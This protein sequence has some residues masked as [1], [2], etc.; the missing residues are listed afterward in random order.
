MKAILRIHVATLMA[1]AAILAAQNL[2]SGQGAGVS[3]QI[4]AADTPPATKPVAVDDGSGAEPEQSGFHHR[5]IIR[6]PRVGV[7]DPIQMQ[8]QGIEQQKIQLQQMAEGEAAKPGE[9]LK[10]RLVGGDLDVDPGGY[11]FHNGQFRAAVEGCN[12][13]WTVS[14]T[15]KGRNPVWHDMGD[16]FEITRYDWD[17]NE[18]GQIYRVSVHL[19]YPIMVQG[20]GVSHAVTYQQF[21]GKVVLQVGQVGPLRAGMNV[22]ITAPTLVQLASEHREEVRKYLSPVL[23]RLSMRELLRPGVTDVYGALADIPADPA[24][25]GK[26]AGILLKLDAD[27]FHTREEASRE[28]A[29]LGAG[30]IVAALRVDPAKLSLEQKSRLDS[31]IAGGRCWGKAA[32]GRNDLAFLV[33]CLQEPDPAVVKSA[34]KAIE[35]LVGHPIEIDQ[36]ADPLKLQDALD[37]LQLKLQKELDARNP[38]PVTVPASKPIAN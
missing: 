7:V 26:L 32:P 38:K 11:N 13:Q 3:G 9:I 21:T 1:T 23:A 4:Q 2:V 18:A 17:Q 24:M 6:M 34:I 29:D 16:T 20:Q 19:G 28:L 37:A 15:L 8:K 36:Q 5:P 10:M 14:T 31:F 33:A 25:A 22:D 12:A 35:V 27:D 30:G